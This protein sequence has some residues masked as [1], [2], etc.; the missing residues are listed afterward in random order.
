VAEA[1]RGDTK[2]EIIANAAVI[3]APTRRST[4]YGGLTAGLEM[5]KRKSEADPDAGWYKCP[6]LNIRDAV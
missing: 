1:I 4:Y 5:E 3:G 6:S 2:H